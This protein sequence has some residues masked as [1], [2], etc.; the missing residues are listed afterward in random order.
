MQF[1]F[2]RHLSK[3]LLIGKT[4]SPALWYFVPFSVFYMYMQL[5]QLSFI[6]GAISSCLLKLF[7]Q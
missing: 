7:D 1:Q 5:G 3:V 2:N 4:E 6:V